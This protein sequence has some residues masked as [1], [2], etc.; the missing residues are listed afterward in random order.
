MLFILVKEFL[1][2]LRYKKSNSYI[3]FFWDT[4]YLYLANSSEKHSVSIIISYNFLNSFNNKSRILRL[5][6]VIF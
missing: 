3:V 4:R 1:W 2:I 6:D 5:K